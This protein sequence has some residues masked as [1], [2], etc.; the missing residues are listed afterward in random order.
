MDDTHEF[1][2]KL[3]DTQN[4]DER[5]RKRQRHGNSSENPGKKLPGKQH[6]TN[7]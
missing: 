1:V 2:A 7:K 6:S 4:K 5:N 3:H